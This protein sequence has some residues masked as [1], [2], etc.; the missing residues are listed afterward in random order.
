MEVHLLDRDAGRDEIA[1]L[2]ILVE[3]FEAV[4]QPVRHRGA[5]VG[6]K[7]G[8]LRETR[9]R[10]DAWHDRRV[11]TRR[12]TSVTEIQEDVGVEEELRDRAARSRVDLAL[13]VVE[14]R[15]GAGGVMLP[16]HAPLIIDYDYTIA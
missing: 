5:A 3:P 10:Q 12:G 15:L 7:P 6:G 9:D 4:A 14:I 2:D 8:H 13:E 11:D 16:N 1:R